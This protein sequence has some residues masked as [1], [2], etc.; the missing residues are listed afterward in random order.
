MKIDY[1]K[2][3]KGVWNFINSKIFIF[4]IVGLLFLLWMNQCNRKHELKNEI[5]KQEQNINALKDTLTIV[6]NNNGDLQGEISGFIATQKE[7]RD[8]NK[9]LADEVKK[10]KGNVLSLNQTVISLKQDTSILRK[11]LRDKDKEPEGPI[12]IND[13]TYRIPWRLHY[14]YD[15]VNYDIFIG[16]TDVLSKYPIENLGSELLERNSKIKLIWGQ[17]EEDGKLKVFVTS[18]YPGFTPESLEGVLID[19]NSNKY[20]RKMIDDRHWFTGFSIGL[21]ITTGWDFFR[22]QPS[23]VVGPSLQYSIYNW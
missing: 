16:K 2:L 6:K 12:F 7:L 10:Q 19:P 18:S 1:K 13:S 9:G 17:K 20:I 15:S 21:G 5:K 11:F 14:Q 8:L 22:Q 23:I 3:L 4:V